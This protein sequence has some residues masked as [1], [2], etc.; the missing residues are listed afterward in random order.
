MTNGPQRSRVAAFTTPCKQIT[1]VLDDNGED[2]AL[3]KALRAEQGV[4]SA[5]SVSCMGSSI[6][7]EAKVKPGKL[8][9][10]VLVRMIM[11]LV[12]EADA[13]RIFDYIAEKVK[14]YD[15][16]ESFLMQIPAPMATSYVLPENV[17]DE[18]ERRS[19]SRP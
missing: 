5:H 2:V 12:Q 19:A 7:G 15:P 11:V 8:P 1:C 4:V 13:D 3:M 14:I 17:P 6:A 9:E 18:K 10:P 16:N